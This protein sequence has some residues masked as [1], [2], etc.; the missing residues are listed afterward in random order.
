MKKVILLLFVGICFMVS[1]KSKKF[2]NVDNS[3]KVE[4][5]VNYI[6]YFLE[7]QK[8][9]S[10]YLTNNFEESYRKLDS[11]F[12]KY[13]PIN[14]DTYV[15]YGIYVNSAV[16]SNHIEDIERKVRN[17][18]LNFGAITPRHKDWMEID[19]KVFIVAKLSKEEVDNL[20]EQYKSKLDLELRNCLKKMA[21][22]DQEIR[23]IKSSENEKII[24]DEKNGRKLDSIFTKYGYPSNSIMGT[25]NA[26]FEYDDFVTIHIFFLHQPDDFKNKYLPIILEN[27][28]KGKCEPSTYAVIKDRQMLENSNLQYFGSYKSEDE[29][30]LPLYNVKKIDSI[31]KSIGLPNISYDDWRLEK[32]T[33]N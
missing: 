18:Y 24:V 16:M 7:V 9:D 6:P 1:C 33:R 30:L 23:S 12:K 17:G 20:V 32:L 8:A 3:I 19:N 15:E 4:K 5:E 11:L 14:S 25:N 28:K 22:D 31:R 10:L 29:K 2:V 13:D 27:I 21:I 26:F